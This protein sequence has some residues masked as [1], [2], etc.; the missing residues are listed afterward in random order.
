M[1]IA[2]ASDDQKLVCGHVGRCQ[3]FL[4]YTADG[5]KIT[6]REYR[7]NTFTGHATGK[8]QHHHH[9]EVGGMGHPWIQ[10]ALEG[11][12]VL[13]SQGMGKRLW[14]DLAALNIK[15]IITDVENADVA[16]QNYLEGTLPT[17]DSGKACRH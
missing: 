12:S 11:C 17:F 8:E 13:I 3:G 6:V 15:P 7:P 5:K 4:V 1:K 14:D 16:A 9:G 10:T 2:I